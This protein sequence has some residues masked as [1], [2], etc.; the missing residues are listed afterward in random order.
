MPYYQSHTNKPL[1]GSEP[2]DTK[3]DLTGDS[4][5]WLIPNLCPFN[6]WYAVI[7]LS[8]VNLYIL[9]AG[10]LVACSPVKICV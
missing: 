10:F 2:S 5:I 7:S 8:S 1:S 9:T 6:Y 4:T 3:Y